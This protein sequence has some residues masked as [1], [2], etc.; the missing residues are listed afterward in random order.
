MGNLKNAFTSKKFYAAVI[1]L[2]FVFAG[3]RAGLSA[4]TV[5]EAIQV[6]MT[7]IIGQGLADIR[8]S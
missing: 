2:V 1:A 6:I 7:Y 4:E 3:E 5:T 8:K